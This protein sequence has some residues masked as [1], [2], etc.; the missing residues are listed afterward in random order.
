M[1]Y[2]EAYQSHNIKDSQ[3]WAELPRHEREQEETGEEQTWLAVAVAKGTLVA[4]VAAAD[5][6]AEE[7]PCIMGTWGGK[8]TQTVE[9]AKI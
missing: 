5:T 6:V 9:T 7:A 3:A 1:H 4:D 2:K 8:I